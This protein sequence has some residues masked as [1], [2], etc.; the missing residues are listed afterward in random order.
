MVFRDRSYG[1]LIVSASDQF[2]TKTTELLSTGDFWPVR[3]A[4]GAGEARRL[5]A[6]RAF[7]VII[8]S[9]PLPDENGVSLA[10]DVCDRYGSAVMLLAGGEHFEELCWKL[11]ERGILCVAKPVTAHMM[12]QSVRACCAMVE[13]LRRAEAKQA[14]IEE[15]IEEIRLVNRANCVIINERGMS[16]PEAH[17]FI[18]KEAMDRR[19]PRSRVAEEI[20]KD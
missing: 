4:R 19:L 3:C 18:E 16:E 13:R 17:R 15:K 11:T 12:L 6:A 10:M 14:T 20:L 8:I 1:V 7:E 2:N 5:L 9:A